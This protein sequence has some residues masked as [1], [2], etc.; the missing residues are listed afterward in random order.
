M[1]AIAS[2]CPVARVTAAPKAVVR[3]T[4]ARA[5]TF[6]GSVKAFAPLGYV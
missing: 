3:R 5:S 6:S 2:I 4:A 1:A